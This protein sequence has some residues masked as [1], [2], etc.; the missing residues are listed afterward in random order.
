M[1]KIYLIAVFL[2]SGCT[3]FTINATMCD[4]IALD[5]QAIMPQECRNYNE[6]EAEKSFNK[7]RKKQS[8]EDI[9]EF[10]KEK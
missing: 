6:K 1:W 2:L 5:P 9:I 8:A 10:N 7:T 4:Q 3:T